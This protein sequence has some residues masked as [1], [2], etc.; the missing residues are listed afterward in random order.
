MMVVPQKID[1]YTNAFVKILPLIAYIIPIAV[2]YFLY[3]S[4]FEMTWKGRTFYLFFLW[5]VCLEMILGW[6]RIQK[7]KVYKLKRT[8][9]GLTIVA[10]LCPTIYVF[11]A[12]YW[13]LNRAILDLATKYG[14]RD[15][16]LN[17]MPLSIEYLAFAVFFALVISLYY[18]PRILRSFWISVFFLGIIGATYTLD[19]LY[20]YG[21]FTP[22]QIFVPATATLAA[23]VLSMMGFQ[24]S[25]TRV[26]EGVPF[27]QVSSARGSA[28]LGISWACSGVESLL[29]YTATILLFL[30]N[31]SV[32]RI[33]KL[34][35]FAIG[36]IVTYFIN[37][38][39]IVTLFLIAIDYGPNSV[40][41]NRFHE[42][43][44]SL[45][46]ITWIVLYPLIIIGSQILWAR[47]KNRREH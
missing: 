7:P 17:W 44:G 45:Y 9:T 13:G 35:Y 32:P 31:S 38:F 20:P 5:L 24:V 27:L 14:M 47:I 11:A 8:R 29:I 26:L 30:K 1:R 15:S 3:P 12:N 36:A 2:L 33:Q 37:I 10:L 46:S 40:P 19:N 21:Q 22:F 4:S 43:Y 6:E 41:F 18:G 25:W 34:I 39:R 23:N 16:W 42:Y 28:E